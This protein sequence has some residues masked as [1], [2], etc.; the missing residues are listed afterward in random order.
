MYR[1]HVY[2]WISL[3]IYIYSHIYIDI[4]ISMPVHIHIHIHI[5][6]YVYIYVYIYTHIYTTQPR[7]PTM[8]TPYMFITSMLGFFDLHRQASP[9]LACVWF[10][11]DMCAEFVRVWLWYCISIYDI[12]ISW[13]SWCFPF[14]CCSG[15][16]NIHSITTS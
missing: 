2:A 10:S 16:H 3:Y 5:H 13:V 14:Q 1:C 4:H 9:G 8:E 15:T 11:F 12:I 6:I 7:K